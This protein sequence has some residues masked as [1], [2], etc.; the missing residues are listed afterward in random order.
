MVMARAVR[1]PTLVSFDTPLNTVLKTFKIRPK[2][3]KL[4]KNKTP[5]QFRGFDIDTEIWKL[6]RRNADISADHRLSA[7]D[8]N[9]INPGAKFAQIYSWL[10]ACQIGFF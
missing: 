2:K 10:V 7:F 4:R 6:L 8:T 1:A 9:H 5:V 3:R